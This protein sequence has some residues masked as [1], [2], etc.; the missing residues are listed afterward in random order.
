MRGG[1][2]GRPSVGRKKRVTLKAVREDLEAE[3]VRHASDR[4]RYEAYAHELGADGADAWEL[5]DAAALSEEALRA[6]GERTG[7]NPP[8]RGEAEEA[9]RAWLPEEARQELR[10]AEAALAEL[11]GRSPEKAARPY[12]EQAAIDEAEIIADRARA[13]LRHLQDGAGC[14]SDARIAAGRDDTA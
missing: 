14:G 2:N 1:E 3:V 7:L 13:V 10:A 9:V 12:R 5:R 11:L 4:L 6:F 8:S